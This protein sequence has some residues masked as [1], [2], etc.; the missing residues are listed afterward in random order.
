M[1][2]RTYLATLGSIATGGAAMVG[3]SAAVDV[4]RT[5][6]A[7]VSVVTDSKGLI[8][9]TAGEEN[10]EFAT[11]DG[12]SLSIDISTGN[13]EGLNVDTRTVIDDIFRIRNQSGNDQV[14]WIKDPVDDGE[15]LFGDAGPLHF[16]RGPVSTTN[17]SGNGVLGARRRVF[18]QLDP[19]PGTPDAKQRLTVVGLVPPKA[20]IGT[21]PG[22]ARLAW[23]NA[24][25]P[26]TVV[27]D[28]EPAISDADRR[29]V[30]DATTLGNV[31][32]DPGVVVGEE[33]GRYFLKP[34][35]EMKIGLA[36]DFSGFDAGREGFELG[37]VLDEIE[38]VGRSLADARSLA[39]GETE[40]NTIP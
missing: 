22:D 32:L 9:L 14:V 35:E 36:A 23:I 10:G 7:N 26:V 31:F 25:H 1:Q 40:F 4:W 39:T 16:F 34:G 5:T 29:A 21:S 17:D 8:G 18:S 11:T 33:K 15:E 20:N 27:K 24:G 28:G 30:G 19:V 12:G 13:A 2:R 38:I 3:T 6:S 37:K